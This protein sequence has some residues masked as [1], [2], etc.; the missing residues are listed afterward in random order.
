MLHDIEDESCLAHGGTGCDQDQ[1]RRLQSRGLLV[2]VD[3]ACGNA[4]DRTAVHES[5]MDPLHDIH[6]HFF[7]GPDLGG[8][9]G[10]Q[11]AED[12]LLCLREKFVHPVRI[13]VAPVLDLLIHL[14]QA[15]LHCLFVDDPGIALYIC[16]SRAVVKDT[17]DKIDPGDFRRNILLLQL[18]LHR[19]HVH[20]LSFVEE[21]RNTLENDP[22]LSGVKVVR[23]ADIQRRG[24]RFLIHQHGAQDRLLCLQTVRQDPF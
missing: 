9:P 23:A 22:V 21:L 10:F 18:C 7:Y 20:G 14:D 1:V 12:L 13:R 4:G 3:K 5:R 15:P 16:G 6:S 2:Q 19:D 8:A 11:N 17:A 24:H